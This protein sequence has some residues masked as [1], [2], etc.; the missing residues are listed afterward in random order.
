MSQAG[1]EQLNDIGLKELGN[2][3]VGTKTGALYYQGK[4]V[5]TE[6]VVVLSGRQSFW[7]ILVAVM[8]ALSSGVTIVTSTNLGKL[9]NWTPTVS[10]VDNA[11][12]ATIANATTNIATDIRTFLESPRHSE[13]EGDSKPIGSPEVMPLGRSQSDV[14]ED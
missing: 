9:L 3:Q 12:L 7:V 6:S 11:A 13:A 14:P 5:Q 1:G 8:T 2:F 10:A 4:R